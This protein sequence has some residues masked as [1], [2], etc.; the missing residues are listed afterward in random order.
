MKP[1]GLNNDQF[2]ELFARHCE[3]RPLDLTR[4]ED[5][6]AAIHDCDTAI[7]LDIKIALGIVYRDAQ[8]RDNAASR[9]AERF[10]TPRN[11][12]GGFNYKEYP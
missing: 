1:L 2:R 9:C 7:L 12:H 3:C 8:E 10:H 11:V 4:G 5:D 6:H